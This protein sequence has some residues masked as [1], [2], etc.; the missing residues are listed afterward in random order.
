[1]S[2]ALPHRT[3]ERRAERGSAFLFVLLVLL[4]LS[5]LGLSL[6]VVTQSEVQIGGAQKQTTRVFY[7]AD[8]GLRIQLAAHLVNGDV[9]ARTR[10][11]GNPLVLQT[12]PA[13]GIQIRDLVEVSPF[14]PIFS[15]TC[16]LCM[17]NPDSNY[18]S[19]NHAVTATGLRIGIVSPL[20]PGTEQAR[21]TVAQMFS[22]QPWE[23]TIT[24]IQQVD[25]LSMIRY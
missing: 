19:I 10:A 18:N 22:L 21:R 3:P 16:N 15:G 9:A 7:A 5:I 6:A 4:V 8:S 14:Y 17:V 23:P 12:T 2:A 24:A 11:L 13:A 25:D 20:D 1:M